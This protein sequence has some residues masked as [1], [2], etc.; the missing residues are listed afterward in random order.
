[1]NKGEYDSSSCQ[2]NEDNDKWYNRN[3]KPIHTVKVK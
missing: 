2:N 3:I 1:M